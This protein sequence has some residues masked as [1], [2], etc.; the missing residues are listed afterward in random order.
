M[1][2]NCEGGVEVSKDLGRVVGVCCGGLIA[3]LEKETK[4]SRAKNRALVAHDHLDGIGKVIE[5]TYIKYFCIL[6]PGTLFEEESFRAH[7]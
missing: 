5:A 7:P 6:G 4:L 2:E 3:C 1:D